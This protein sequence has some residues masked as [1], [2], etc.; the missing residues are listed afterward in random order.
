MET[1][2]NR[3]SVN[4]L[5]IDVD[6]LKFLLPLTEKFETYIEGELEIDPF[7]TWSK[8]FSIA[9]WYT[10]YHLL[11]DKSLIVDEEIKSLFTEEKLNIIWFCLTDRKSFSIKCSDGDKWELEKYTPNEHLEVIMKSL[12][13][14]A[15][16]AGN[17]T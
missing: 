10:Q 3:K 17:R 8:D 2:P 15:K 5:D 1:E 13:I 7:R 12:D 4:I 16:P 11:R 6:S 9:Y 14:K